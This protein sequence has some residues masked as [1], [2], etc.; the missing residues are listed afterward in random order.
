MTPTEAKAMSG[1]HTFTKS[2][3]DDWKAY[4]RVR[5]GGRYNMF[6]PRAKTAAGLSREEYMFCLK[7]YTE[8]KESA[9][10]LANGLSEKP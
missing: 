6:D 4:E 2:Q 1:K 3:I 10:A 8:L 7:N 9:L 5:K